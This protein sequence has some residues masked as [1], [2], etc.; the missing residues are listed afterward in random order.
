MASLTVLAIASALVG[1]FLHHSFFIYGEH[2]LQATK[3]VQFGCVS[4]IVCFTLRARF[5]E[6]NAL[7][8]TLVVAA[9][10]VCAIFASMTVYRLAFHPL[11]DFPGPP[12]WR[13]SKL[14]HVFKV[15]PRQ[16]NHL[17]LDELYHEY[18]PF[19]RTGE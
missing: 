7:Q 13:V 10:F 15:A 9:S 4:F 6:G 18:G 5:G 19:V 2:H 14:W 1:L 16:Q 11:R 17:L 8:E 3:Y 12:M